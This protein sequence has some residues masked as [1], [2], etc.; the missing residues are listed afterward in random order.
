MDKPFEE[1]E[2]SE[3]DRAI[4]MEIRSHCGRRPLPFSSITRRKVERLKLDDLARSNDRSSALKRGKIV[5]P[6]PRS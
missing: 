6:R 3:S 1:L 2:K 5:A 4:L